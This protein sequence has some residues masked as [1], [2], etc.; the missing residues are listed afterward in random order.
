MGRYAKPTGN[1]VVKLLDTSRSSTTTLVDDPEL[2]IPAL[3]NSIYMVKAIILW[4][5]QGSVT[6]GIKIK[7]NVP[8]GSIR[9]MFYMANTNTTTG[10]AAANTAP[11][12]ILNNS[13]AFEVL[14]NVSGV[15]DVIIIDGIIQTVNAGNITVQWAQSSSSV[16]VTKVGGYSWLSLVKL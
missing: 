4:D 16:I 8:S 2:S 3:A 9:S 10:G 5:G 12:S 6:N 11:K 7:I 14:P 15:Q 1:P 13:G